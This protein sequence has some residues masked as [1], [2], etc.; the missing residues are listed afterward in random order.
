MLLLGALLCLPL[1]NK[2]SFKL[3]FLICYY[4]LNCVYQ[5]QSK[6]K[7][8]VTLALYVGHWLTKY[9]LWHQHWYSSIPLVF[10][11]ISLISPYRYPLSKLPPLGAHTVGD[12]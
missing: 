1:F 2:C 8:I 5:R 12:P 6:D 9:W 10:A 7:D 4:L 3:L 11:G